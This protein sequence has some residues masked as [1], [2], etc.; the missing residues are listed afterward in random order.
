MAANGSASPVERQTVQL[1]SPEGTRLH[2]SGPPGGLT[3]TIPLVNTGPDKQKIRNVAVNTKKLQGPARVPLREFAFNA[4]LYGGEQVDALATIVLDSR[5]PPGT[6]DF[7][8]TVGDKTLPATAHVS[9]VVD[10]RIAPNQITILAGTHTSYK[11]TLVFENAGNV[12]LP[13]GAR[14]EAPI[15]DS[16]DL[17][18]SLIIGLH[19]GDRASAESMAKAFLN[20][21]A[22]LQAGI[23]VAHRKPTV[24]RPGQKIAVDVEF[25]LP[26]NLKPLRHYRSGHQLYDASVGVDIYTSLNYGSTRKSKSKTIEDIVK[27]A[28]VYE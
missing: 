11:R 24:I 27:E 7:E 25:Q 20:E 14:C 16:F 4:R 6:Y 2:F 15:F 1:A 13:T 5:T 10:L 17:V 3:G 21:W 18:S 23:L 19:K 26:P 22:D 12:P 9:E 28:P 8:V